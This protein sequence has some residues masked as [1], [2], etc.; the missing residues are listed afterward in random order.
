MVRHT[1]KAWL[2]LHAQ[3]LGWPDDSMGQGLDNRW[4]TKMGD[5]SAGADFSELVSE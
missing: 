3:N 2:E 1:F 5:P 4:R